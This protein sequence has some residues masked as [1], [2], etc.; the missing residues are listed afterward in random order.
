MDVISYLDRVPMISMRHMRRQDLGLS[1]LALW[2]Q[3]KKHMKACEITLI[4]VINYSLSM[5]LITSQ[6]GYLCS[7]V[8]C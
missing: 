2:F 4:L 6:Q 7:Q 5:S 3:L 1:G 8:E